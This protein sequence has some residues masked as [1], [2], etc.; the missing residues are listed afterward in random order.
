MGTASISGVGPN[1]GWATS[2]ETVPVSMSYYAGTTTTGT[3]IGAPTTAGTY[4]VVESFAGSSDYGSAS[5]A[6]TFTI[7]PAT[8]TV[9]ANDEANGFSVPIGEVNV[10]PAT[11]TASVTESLDFDQSPG[12]SVG[13]NPALVYNSARATSQPIIEVEVPTD[14]GSGVPTDIKVTL[15]VDGATT[16]A[17]FDPS[18]H[19]AGSTYLLAVQDGSDVTSSGLYDWDAI[20]EIDYTSGSVM[21][22]GSGLATGAGPFGAG[23]G[24]A[25]VDQLLEQPDGD[26]L[27]LTGSGDIRDYTAIASGSGTTTYANF[28]DNG[29]LVESG[30]GASASF[31]YTA[32]DQTKE[33][34]NPSP[35]SMLLFDLA[36]IVDRQ[37][38]TTLYEYDSSGRLTEVVASD[39]GTTNLSYST[40]SVNIYEPGSRTVT[41]GLSGGKL[42]GITDAA[43][44]GRTLAY[45]SD[46]LL[47][48]DEWLPYDTTIGYNADGSVASVQLGSA[49]SDTWDVTAMV[50]RELASS[51][52]LST[53]ETAQLS[54]TITNPLSDATTYG[55]DPH[56]AEIYQYDPAGFEQIWGRN[57]QEQVTAYTDADGNATTYDYSAGNV[58][59]QN[60]PDGGSTTYT[61]NSFQEVTVEQV[62]LSSGAE[63]TTS[64]S[65]DGSGNLTQMI[66]A[67][68]DTTTYVWSGQLLQ[69]QTDAYGKTTQY[70]YDADRRQTEVINPD[71]D[72]SWTVYD[73]A[74]N[75][76]AA[77]DADGNTSYTSYDGDDRLVDRIDGDGNASVTYYDAAGKVTFTTNGGNSIYDPAGNVTKAI[78]A[79][80]H[81]SFTYFDHEVIGR[82]GRHLQFGQTQQVLL[83]I[84]VGAGR[85]PR[86][87]LELGM[88][89]GQAQLLQVGLHQQR[90]GR[91]GPGRRRL[92]H[93]SPWV[94]RKGTGQTD[95]D[96]PGAHARW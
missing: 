53:D 23:W 21:E 42:V 66:D 49:A 43:G 89:G 87:L 8:L 93:I 92:R 74:G 82:A 29:G 54:G 41:L 84:L 56:G 14:A 96:S 47:T 34:F 76:A 13:Q 85:F 88:H 27:W 77:I 15:F 70:F 1:T 6:V 5:T 32:P 4:T 91:R 18:G 75:P 90:V 57:A 16:T 94:E 30:G 20:V 38:L 3:A 39:G 17:T 7:S 40:S 86:Q 61:Y 60:D 31:V 62:A 59:Q 45:N 64:Y 63:A 81:T 68:G 50:E 10:S 26:V 44:N 58:T 51:P 95:E 52:V 67:D 24:I 9:A 78:D 46:H 35:T 65:Y 80:G 55:V 28:E 19:S 2:L 79:D 71:G 36:E 11:G 83:V 22:E 12:T 37:N 25:G 48:N 73:A 69:S 72:T 33:Y